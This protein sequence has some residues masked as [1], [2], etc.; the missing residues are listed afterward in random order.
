MPTIFVYI[1]GTKCICDY[2]QLIEAGEVYDP[3]YVI[4]EKGK[5]HFT[6]RQLKPGKKDFVIS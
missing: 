4:D 5:A 3:R 2:S 1:G 6:T